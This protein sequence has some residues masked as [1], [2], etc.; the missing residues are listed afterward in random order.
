M[1]P[2]PPIWTQGKVHR[3]WA[4]FRENTAYTQSWYSKMLFHDSEQ[5][6]INYPAMKSQV[7]HT[8]HW[9]HCR[10]IL[11]HRLLSTDNDS[12]LQLVLHRWK[13]HQPAWHH[14]QYI[15]QVYKCLIITIINLTYWAPTLLNNII[16]W[17]FI[18]TEPI[19][20][21]TAC[22]QKQNLRSMLHTWHNP[23]G[24]NIIQNVQL[25]PEIMHAEGITTTAYIMHQPHY[26][27]TTRAYQ[28]M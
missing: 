5:P 10:P 22:K 19:L 28:A 4:L 15:L 3:P 27:L 8:Q 18:W 12:T 20:V 14:H 7:A 16:M 26:R 24:I 9:H 17:V 11:C 25:K 23:L 1:S 2:H 6:Q 21:F 13:H